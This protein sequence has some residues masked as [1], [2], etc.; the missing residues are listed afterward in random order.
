VDGQRTGTEGIE[1]SEDN[2]CQEIGFY[3]NDAKKGKL[4]CYNYGGFF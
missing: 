2:D 3:D 1:D 4:I